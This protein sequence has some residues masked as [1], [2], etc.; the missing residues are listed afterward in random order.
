MAQRNWLNDIF[1]DVDV[2]AF[3]DSLKFDAK[4]VRCGSGVHDSLIGVILHHQDLFMFT[5]TVRKKGRVIFMD[6]NILG[7]SYKDNFKS[8]AGMGTNRNSDGSQYVNIVYLP[9]L[10]M[11][12][13]SLGLDGIACFHPQAKFFFSSTSVDPTAAD[14]MQYS[15]LVDQLQIYTINGIL[16]MIID[17]VASEGYALLGNKQSSSAKFL[18]KTIDTF[19]Y[20]HGCNGAVS[21][22]ATNHNPSPLVN[23]LNS[24]LTY[25]SILNRIG[26]VMQTR[27]SI[28]GVPSSGKPFECTQHKGPLIKTELAPQLLMPVVSSQFEL[29]QDAAS[30][31]A[32]RDDQSTAGDT[33]IAWWVR[34]DFVSFAG[35]C[36][37]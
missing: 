23:G 14:Y 36:I 26:L 35:T 28:L 30:W 25:I 27:R 6:T 13:E 24:A 4:L 33:V 32:F 20:S 9:I 18:A 19:T 16:S 34:K 31:A 17:C 21:L 8:I 12:T 10:G 5:E 37:W 11:I 2:D 15:L 22:G 3:V 7:K 1:T 29:G